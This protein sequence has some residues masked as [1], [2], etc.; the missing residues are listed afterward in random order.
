MCGLR[1]YNSSNKPPERADRE[2][3]GAEGPVRSVARRCLTGR[4]VD[5]FHVRHSRTYGT[6]NLQENEIEVV[7]ED[8][9]LQIGGA[10]EVVV[11]KEPVEAGRSGEHVFVVVIED[12]GV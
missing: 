12:G 4:I 3:G 5:C 10:V 9:V 8:L 1:G 7:G 6:V 11:K 2:P